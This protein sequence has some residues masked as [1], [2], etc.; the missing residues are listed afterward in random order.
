M[1]KRNILISCPV[2]GVDYVDTFLEYSLGSL[3]APGNIP[4]AASSFA[5]TIHIITSKYDVAAIHNHRHYKHALEYC[6]FEFSTI[7]SLKTISNYAPSASD[8][9]KYHYLSSLQN[10]SIQ[11]SAAYDILIFNYAD[12]VWAECSMANLVRMLDND[13][14]AVL[15][16]CLP[17]DHSKARSRLSPLLKTEAPNPHLPVSARHSANLA[18]DCLEREARLRVW[19]NPEFTRL[20]S[21]LI[22]EVPNQ[23]AIV[24]AY[25]QTTLAIRPQPNN[26]EYMNGIVEGTLDQ[27]F[28]TMIS[29]TGLSIIHAANSDDVMVFSL[30]KSVV[31]T[32]VSK[33]QT[34]KHL[35]SNLEQNV[36]TEQMGFAMQ[37]IRVR[38]RDGDEVIW[39]HTEIFS[40]DII[41][42]IHDFHREA[43]ANAQ[44]TLRRPHP[45]TNIMLRVLDG[46]LASRLAYALKRLLGRNFSRTLRVNYERTFG[47]RLNDD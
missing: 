30:Y 43:S 24:R 38:Y 45:R 28:S 36:S 8:G 9:G 31:D 4:A 3:L 35:L 46:F 26:D 1:D 42:L 23:G 33:Q 39:K 32:R 34:A 2:W 40:R 44:A 16:F 7:E 29:G 22:W 37:P 18:I 41:S 14:Q 5:I 27:H 12:F 21:Y 11:L 10:I 20:P 19:G 25:H 6:Q 13:H 15:G 17:V 47:R